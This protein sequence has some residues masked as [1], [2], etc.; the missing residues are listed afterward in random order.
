MV[1]PTLFEVGDHHLASTLHLKRGQQA[2][3]QAMNY[4]Q[5]Q[6]L[7]LVQS[8][9]RCYYGEIDIIMQDHEV[10][11]FV[12][13]RYRKQ[14]SHGDCLESIT[15]HKQQKILKTAH[16]YLHCQGI[17]EKFP[18]RFDVIAIRPYNSPRQS[19]EWIKNAFS[20]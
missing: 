3:A 11:V 16:Y 7:Q 6:G 9:F 8:N 20:G 4:L 2:E 1:S 12:E 18:Y 10:L 5:M 13:V 17:Y 14:P 15:L 19:I